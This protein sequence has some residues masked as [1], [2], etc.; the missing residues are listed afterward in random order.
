MA[1]TSA[2]AAG[3]AGHSL[4]RGPDRIGSAVAAMG[5]GPLTEDGLRRHVFPL[6]SKV[7][8]R[9]ELYLANHSLGRPLDQT[10]DDVRE[11]ASR[12]MEGMD[13]AWGPWLDEMNAWRAGVARLIGLS[14]GDAVVPKVAAGQ[15][16]RAVL[17]ALPADGSLRPLTIVA[18]RG[19][20]DAL[21]FVLKM[22]E[23]KGRA[24]I[25]WVEPRMSGEETGVSGSAPDVTAGRDD[26]ID[27]LP[28]FDSHDVI[29]AIEPGVDL[30]IVSQVY[31]AT[32]QVLENLAGI[33]AA[34]KN[35]GALSLIDMYHG[36]GVLPGMFDEISPDFAVG[37]SYKYARGGPG[38]AWLAVH[39]RHL[40]ETGSADER[41]SAGSRPR[42]RTLDTGWF[43]KK[44]TFGFARPDEPLLT[45]GGDAWMENTPAPILAYQARAGLGLVLAIGVDRLRAY[46]LEQQAFLRE[47]LARR[48]VRVRRPR[49]HGAYLLLPAR[50]AAAL[51]KSLK[52]RGVNTDARLGHVRLCP[53]IL[54][55]REEMA[56]AAEIIAAC[57]RG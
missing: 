49:M 26:N 13:E 23:D 22:Y 19:E 51:V 38:A 46:S 27:G 41:T 6:F 14:R 55:T 39:P 54:N 50:D 42:L 20:F 45:S 35:A 25:R 2:E 28:L 33:V 53:D 9:K 10:E 24:R 32:G 31:Y 48:G 44:D 36:A 29:A 1:T 16:L 11:F 47:E 30:V 18:T 40:T 21:D 57:M 5:P 15:G 56:R 52:Q 37:G 7:L 8:G 34:A 4:A 3:P 17:N 43:A 12:W